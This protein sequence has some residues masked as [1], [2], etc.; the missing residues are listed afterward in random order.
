MLFSTLLRNMSS[1]STLNSRMFF[2]RTPH[3]PTL[4]PIAICPFTDRIFIPNNSIS[5]LSPSGK[6]LYS[7]KDPSILCSIQGICFIG[8][9]IC[10]TDNYSNVI[11]FMTT[12]G[13]VVTR[14]GGN[15]PGVLLDAPTAIASYSDREL[16]I[17]D[18]N[19]NRVIHLFPDLPFS[20]V[21]GR[22]LLLYPVNIEVHDGGIFVLNSRSPCVANFSLD[23]KFISRIFPL[24]DFRYNGICGPLCFTIDEDG[25]FIFSDIRYSF[26]IFSP[27]GQLLVKAGKRR[28]ERIISPIGVAIN[29][30]SQIVCVCRGKQNDIQIF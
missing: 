28:K 12:D 17:C 8:E 3:I 24:E 26:R 15:T 1:F 14:A 4:Q 2:K 5:V 21:I 22:G 23:G 6:Y 13:Y 7:I 30:L 25:N 20:R 11:D 9:I 19:Y 27:T 10:V 29:S 18:N 16:F